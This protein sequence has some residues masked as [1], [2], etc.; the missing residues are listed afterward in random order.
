MTEAHDAVVLAA[1]GSR[2][3]GRPKQSLTIDGETLLARTSRLVAATRPQKLVVVLGAFAD[4]LRLQVSGDLV[5]I[6]PHWAS[7]MA[8]SLQRAA[9]CLAGRKLPVLITVVDQPALGQAHLDALMAAYDGRRDVVTGYGDVRGVPAFVRANTMQL[10]RD[11]KG[12]QGF[13][14]LWLV[15]E[16]LCVRADELGDDLDTEDDI[17]QAVLSGRLDAANSPDQ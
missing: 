6:N 12:E 8:S 5:V 15:D 11:L 2:R 1:G 10:A 4:T 16:P 17:R 7:G 3:L 13:R 14:H 9:D